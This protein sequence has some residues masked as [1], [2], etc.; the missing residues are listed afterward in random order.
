MADHQ[1]T[2]EPIAENDAATGTTRIAQQIRYD[3]FGQVLDGLNGQGTSPD[4]DA[5]ARESNPH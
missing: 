1:G 4:H 3:S 5:L 2:V